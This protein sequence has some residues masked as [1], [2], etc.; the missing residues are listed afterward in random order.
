MMVGGLL[1]RPIKGRFDGCCW[2]W[3]L[4]GYLT[5]YGTRAG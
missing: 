5:L 4:G 3:F 1:G 2:A